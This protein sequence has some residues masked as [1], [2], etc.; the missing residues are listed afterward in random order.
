MRLISTLFAAFFI[1]LY[2]GR[3]DMEDEKRETLLDHHL[4]CPNV[5]LFQKVYVS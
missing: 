3:Q 4:S 5:I 2:I 1:E